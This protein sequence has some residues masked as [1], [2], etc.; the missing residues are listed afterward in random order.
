MR[1][2]I[3]M[4]KICHSC[5]QEIT[6]TAFVYHKF[7]KTQI[8]WFWHPQCYEKQELKFLPLTV[9]A[10]YQLFEYANSIEDKQDKLWV[11]E[12]IKAVENERGYICPKI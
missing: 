1:Y 2:Y 12:I 4:R 9:D 5:E 10:Y 6:G 8:E 11:D 7:E 3:T